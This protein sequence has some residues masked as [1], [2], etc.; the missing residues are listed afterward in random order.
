MEA[1]ELLDNP[2]KWLGEEPKALSNRELAGAGASGVLPN[3]DLFSPNSPPAPKADK[4]LSMQ[5]SHVDQYS[6]RE[7]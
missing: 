4:A 3:I 2:P 1:P 5:C 6:S 7:T